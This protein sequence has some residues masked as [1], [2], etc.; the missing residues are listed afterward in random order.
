MILA[1]ASSG[2]RQQSLDIPKATSSILNIRQ[3]G[4]VGP[5]IG[6]F[7]KLIEPASIMVN[8][9]GDI[10]ISDRATSAI[11]K[12]S[13]DMTPVA[14]EGGLGGY[15]GGFNRPLGMAADAALNIYVA[16]GGNRQIQL[17]DRNMRFVK[18]IASYEDENGES[19]EFVFPSDIAIDNEGFIWVADDDK[20]LKLDPFYRLLFEASQKGAGYFLLGRVSSIEISKNGKVAIADAGNNR[21]VLMSVY[22]NYIG[23]ITTGPISVVTWDG[24]EN[25]WALETGNGRISCYNIAGDPLF[26]YADTGGSRL[27]W[28]SFDREGRLLALDGNQRRL[29]IFEIIRGA[30]TPANK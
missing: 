26:M 18:S 25:L 7:G 28:L 10:F 30:D 13:I 15:G 8:N 21:V 20:V 17:L 2:E 24:N 23:E 5:D 1:C 29:K 19:N 12:L 27:V 4:S 16:D 14:R 6:T 11:Y 9:L 22:G 3:S